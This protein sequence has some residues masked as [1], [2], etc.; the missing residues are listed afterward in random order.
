[1]RVFL[2]AALVAVS[3]SPAL[4]PAA[5]DAARYRVAIEVG[6]A[7]LAKLLESNLDLVR[8][9]T[10]PE[11]SEG[12][13]RQLVGTAPDQVRE[14]LA[15]EGYFSPQIEATLASGE[16]G[17]PLARVRVSPGQPTRVASVEFSV[18]G[19]IESDAAFAQRQ[20]AAREAFTLKPGDVF[21]QQA[22]ADSK[23]R[24]VQSLRTKRYAA[25]DVAL[26]R[27]DIDPAAHEAH[28]LLALDSGPPFVFGG[29]QVDGLRRYPQ[30]VVAN[31][32][33]IRPGDPYDEAQLIKFQRR[34][35]ALRHFGSVAVR[36]DN[37]PAKA[38]AAP[39]L[40]TLGEAKAR[41]VDAGVG[42]STDRGPRAQ[43]EY[44]DRNFIERAWRFNAR[45]KVDR[46]SQEVLAG[47]SLP[48]EASGWR[49]GLETQLRN[50][51]IQGERRQ[52][53]AITG[54]R[55]YTVE[56]YESQAS[57]QML[58]E[59][60]ELADAS[61]D[62]RKAL[63]ASQRWTRNA[64]DDLLAP[65][66]GWWARLQVGGAIEGLYT[67]RSFGRI[68]GKAV[69]LL[70]VK[71]FGTLQLRAEAG[72]V[73]AGSRQD[74]PSAYLFR[75][76]GD[77]TIRGYAYESLGVAEGDAVVGGRYLGVASVEY[78]Q[79]L[80][81]DWG[82]ALF[83]DLGNAVDDLSA[84]RTVSGYGAGVRWSS[85]IGALSLDLAYGQATGEWRVHFNAGIAFR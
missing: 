1:M 23:L 17:L 52:D 9:S 57:L 41:R 60:R 6:D 71:S 77:N 4:A 78:V 3:L 16:A 14:L 65:R 39:V 66:R 35:L 11:V 7:G 79:W 49:N 69:W 29:L 5:P 34:L 20:Q 56:E 36:I 74:I 25:A 51:E 48:L 33:P 75:T 42:F 8:W 82:A 81:K 40:V 53:W 21:R 28:L 13:L 50:Q 18:R 58:T 30:S 15:T 22:W 70:P 55:T 47:F 26:S 63:F 37:D 76:G 24:A 73:L 46:L 2:T 80:R 83:Y 43:V 67:D 31:A 27:A 72:A 54:A 68:T 32:S 85:P 59:Y 84:W 19:A 45:A 62:E 44:N 10:R 12:Q 61:E 38:Q 64:L